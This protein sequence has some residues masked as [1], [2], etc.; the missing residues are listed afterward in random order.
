[1][2]SSIN[3]SI[4]ILWLFPSLI[5]FKLMMGVSGQYDVLSRR[6]RE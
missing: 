4:N 2:Y 1:M 6:S 5:A 3:I